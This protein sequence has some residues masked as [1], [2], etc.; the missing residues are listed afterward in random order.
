MSYKIRIF[1]R[2]F[3]RIFARGMSLTQHSGGHRH[4]LRIADMK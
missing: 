2:I 4:V 3:A 1:T